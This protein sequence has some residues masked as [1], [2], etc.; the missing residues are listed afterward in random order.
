MKQPSRRPVPGATLA[1]AALVVAVIAIVLVPVIRTRLEP[2]AS[3]PILAGGS[4][5]GTPEFESQK[6]QPEALLSAPSPKAAEVSPTAHLSPDAQGQSSMAPAFGV[7]II[8]PAH[9]VRGAEAIHTSG[10]GWIHLGIEWRQ[11]APSETTPVSEYDWE[12]FDGV[13]NTARLYDLRV[14][15]TLGGNPCWAASF[16]RGPVNRVDF[17]R[18]VE[19]VAAVVARYKDIVDDWAIYNEPDAAS[20]ARHTP[21]CIDPAS[22]MLIAFGDHPQ[23]YVETLRTA[24]QTIRSIDPDARVVL[25]GIAYD[26]FTSEAGPFVADFLPQILSRGAGKYFDV[27]NFHYYPEY[28]QRWA[29]EGLPG[30]VGKTH[31]IR[32]IL[33][34]YGLD[35]PMICSELGESSGNIYAGDARSPHTQA[36]AVV[37][38]FAR[39]F[40]VGIGL[41]I[42]YNMND[43][44]SPGDP[45]RFHGLL[46]VA[47][48]PKP[49]LS[50]Y[51]TLSSQL[52]GQVFSRSLGRTEWGAK[53]VEGYVFHDENQTNETI[54]LWS[55]DGNPQAVAL[56][57]GVREVLDIFGEAIDHADYLSVDGDPVFIVRE[58]GA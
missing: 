21:D 18:F 20:V 46:D 47:Y 8:S 53:D 28:D 30:I 52:R 58:L 15:V 36:Q 44:E 43:Y 41:P 9:F 27:M 3:G 35:K 1:I 26:N 56:P 38:L 48:Q 22:P 39:A 14:L 11:L 4:P 50:A 2:P 7:Q 32:A 12:P 23:E 49:A 6:P 17:S 5:P 31:V 34:L 24:F 33:A 57:S 13:M 16:S 37:K 19:Y 51:H 29:K 10:A 55:G 25:G 42:W 40:S 54:I 45:Y